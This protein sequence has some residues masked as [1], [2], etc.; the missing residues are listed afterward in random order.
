MLVCP[1]TPARCVDEAAQELISDDGSAVA[2]PVRDGIPAMIAGRSGPLIRGAGGETRSAAS[3]AA[4]AAVR[5]F[6]RAPRP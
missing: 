4:A 1:I 2:Y 5:P 3:L 6:R